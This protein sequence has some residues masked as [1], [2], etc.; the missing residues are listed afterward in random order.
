VLP[1][2]G[3][4]NNKSKIEM[5][6]LNKRTKVETEQVAPACGN[7]LLAVRACGICGFPNV[8][9]ALK[10][11]SVDLGHCCLSFIGNLSKCNGNTLWKELEIQT[12]YIN[13]KNRNND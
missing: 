5:E 3:D 4:L 8:K 11:N 6:N 2:G 9:P 7:T 13:S 12:N 1:S 10:I